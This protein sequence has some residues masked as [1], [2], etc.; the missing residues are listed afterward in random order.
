MFE[1]N[2]PDDPSTE[3]SYEM[4]LTFILEVST[5]RD[6]RINSDGTVKVV[7]S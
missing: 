2:C 6:F 7:L 4:I 5:C 1:H 3:N